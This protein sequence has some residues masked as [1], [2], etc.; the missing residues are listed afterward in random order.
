MIFEI[1]GIILASGAVGAFLAS[2]LNHVVNLSE[3]EEIMGESIPQRTKNHY[4]V[5][6]SKEGLKKYPIWRQS[7]GTIHEE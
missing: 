1:V 3:E 2:L 7:L 4:Y 6:P 5:V